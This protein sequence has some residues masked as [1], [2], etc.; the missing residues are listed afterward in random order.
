MPLSDRRP[1]PLRPELWVWAIVLLM[2]IPAVLP[3]QSSGQP[4][5]LAGNLDSPGGPSFPPGPTYNVTFTESGLPT[6]TA[7][8][9]SFSPGKEAGSSTNT[10]LV[11]QASNGNYTFSVG[12]ISGYSANPTTGSVAVSGNNTTYPQPIVW[13]P[14]T[15]GVTFTESGLP[16]GT[17][18]TVNLN[19]IVSSVLAPGSIS[20]SI[21]TTL[22]TYHVYSA[23]SSWGPNPSSGSGTLTSPS[24]QFSISFSLVV[25]TATF[26][27]TGLPGGTSWT[28]SLTGGY[29]GSSSTPKIVVPGLPNGTYAY[30]VTSANKSW[31][32]S[33]SSFTVSGSNVQVSITFTEVTYTVSFV[34]SGLPTGTAWNVSLAG[35]VQSSTF[36]T[37]SFSKPNGTYAFSVGS[38]PGWADSPSAGSI[39]VQGRGTAQTILWA[40][41]LYNVTFSE[42]GITSN[43]RWWVNLTGPAGSSSHSGATAASNLIVLGLENG[44][45]TY[46]IAVNDKR[47]QTPTPNG[48]FVVNGANFSVAVTFVEILESVAFVESGLP[49]GLEWWANLTG[50]YSNSSFGTT[51]GFELPNGTYTYHPLQTV[52]RSWAAPGGNFTVVG[53]PVTVTVVFTNIVYPVTFN[54]TGLVGAANWSVDFGGTLLNVTSGGAVTT[55]VP[56]GTYAWQVLPPPSYSVRNLFGN[57]TVRGHP[58]S[59]TIVFVELTYAVTF[60]ETGLNNSPGLPAGTTWWV[61][62]SLT[63]GSP[64]V[65]LNLTGSSGV[66]QLPDGNYSYTVESND[67]SYLPQ[68]AHSA[69]T[70]SGA[71]VSIVVVFLPSAY[72]VTFTATGIPSGAVWTVTLVSNGTS[73]VTGGAVNSAV[74]FALT[75]GTYYYSIPSYGLYFPTPSSGSFSVNGQPVNLTVSFRAEGFVV[76]FTETGLPAG[77]N[78]S[79]AVNGVTQ[80]TTSTTLVFTEPNGTYPFTVSSV[81]G[82]PVSPTSGLVHVSGSALSLTIRF[83]SASGGSG[84]LAPSA[85]AVLVGLIAMEL[86]LVGV[87]LVVRKRRRTPPSPPR[88][89]VEPEV[90]PGRAPA[91]AG[92]AAGEPASASPTH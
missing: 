59:V 74:V 77:T 43:T 82:G 5:T 48:A 72:F 4:T 88:G 2:A 45:Y 29:G 46:S 62:V 9:I 11:V 54:E 44:S 24:T 26:V 73:P 31:A 40:R 16:V 30:T 58:V 10:T 21:S 1:L 84:G 38:I 27:E 36:S 20:F 67:R 19:G 71:P 7:W 81:G 41:A 60:S 39:T 76:T 15:Y 55:S 49:A 90:D 13:T 85:V 17:G 80:S 86:L 89:A 50:G 78:W 68:V 70:V 28:V 35:V 69:F 57:L 87:V 32:S 56:N 61:N 79:V 91:G 14:T 66:T 23:N 52:N 18:W 51:I 25:Y 34:E 6:G 37:I 64:V 47:F 75:N 12:P 63:N 3:A 8:S 53:A 83:G 42:S 65:S 22:Y 33:G 92:G